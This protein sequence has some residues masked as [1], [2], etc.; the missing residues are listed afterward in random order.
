MKKIRL[1]LEY[2]CFPVWIYGEDGVMI[3]NDLPEELS[4][5]KE[6]E[7]LCNKIQKEYDGLFIN[8]E[9]EFEYKGFSSLADEK[10]FNKETE[11]LEKVLRERCDGLYIIQNDINDL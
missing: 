8:S 2:G 3:D 1:L 9:V 5:D 10:G 11:L 4:S 6:L 7:H